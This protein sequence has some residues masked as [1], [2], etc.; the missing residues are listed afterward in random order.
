[1]K[2]MILL[3]GAL[4]LVSAAAS[5]AATTLN[6]A[7]DHCQAD[8]GVKIKTSA[9]ASTALQA[10]LV[11]SMVPDQA[12]VDYQGFVGQVQFGF[13]SAIPAW[14]VPGCSAT[15]SSIFGFAAD[16]NASI[17]A[18]DSYGSSDA[19]ALAAFT[20]P[21]P[22]SAGPNAFYME[23]TG[24]N[25]PTGGL[26]AL[27]ANTE[28]YMGSLTVK[29]TGTSTCTGCA[30]QA[31]INFKGAGLDRLGSSTLQVLG[32]ALNGAS[33]VTWQNPNPASLAACNAA[34][35][36]HSSSWGAVKALYR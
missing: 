3:C 8:G 32:T 33:W 15:R 25:D 19:A 35:P 26:P 30:T 24:V 1:M 5:F 9:C 23:V 11:L 12:F 36:T 2:K 22:F 7:Y 16:N 17:C 21:A 14:W 4:L 31:C 6:L 34:S 29:G 18:L 28:V 10:T 27:A 20:N 13:S